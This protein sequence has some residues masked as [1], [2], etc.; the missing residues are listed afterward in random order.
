MPMSGCR[1]TLLCKVD[2]VSYSDQAK[3][4][5]SELGCKASNGTVSIN[6]TGGSLKMVAQCVR[7]PAEYSDGVM[8]RVGKSI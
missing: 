4:A 6:V 2:T 5:R 7:V 3:V 8:V 1:Y